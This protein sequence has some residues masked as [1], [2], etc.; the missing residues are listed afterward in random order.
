MQ[1]TLA[2]SA[3]TEVG[4]TSPLIRYYQ[5]VRAAARQVVRER[6]GAPSPT[7]SFDL[8]P[9][10]ERL[11]RYFDQPGV[12]LAP[13]GAERGRSLWML[14]LMGDPETRTTKTLASLVMVARAAH[15]IDRTG[16]GVLIVTP[17]SANKATALRAA[18]GRAYR[19]GLATPEQLRIVAVA[20]ATSAAKLRAGDLSA[21]AH[22]RAANPF[23][24]ADVDHPAN[25]KQLAREAVDMCAAEI[26]AGTGFR[27]WYSLDIDNY[28]IADS[29]RAFVEAETMP[30]TRAS[31]PRL[32]AHAVSS[33]Y[34]LLGY[35]LGWRLL[36]SGAYADLATPAS[37]PGF[38]LVQQLATPDMVLSLRYG[39]TSHSRIPEYRRD[40]DR[41]RQSADPAF[42]AVTDDPHEVLDRTFY[43]TNPPTCSQIDQIVARHGGGGVVVSRRE[44]LDRYDCVRQLCAEAG[45]RLPSDP[46]DIREWSIVKAL[47]GIL[48]GIER[49]FI[50]EGTDV[51]VHGSGFYTDALLPPLPE[52]HVRRLS[53]ATELA[54]VMRT[55]AS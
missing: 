16:E 18:V 42:P 4:F 35:H 51:V 14:N 45:V 21:D 6:D 24:L 26:L 40:G 2:S 46:A 32:H 41:W 29:V 20:P 9:L 39:D 33:A 34:G 31:R 23:V 52:E 19:T 1:P 10:D 22:L 3:P 36:S 37:H 30:L 15:H 12:T 38:F 55:A 44:C 28:R 50:A 53:R 47:T 49:G 7:V 17:S 54:A 48:V 25:V 11:R 43:T 13:I 5:G 8:P 27:T